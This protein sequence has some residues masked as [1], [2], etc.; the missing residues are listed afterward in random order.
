MLY[1][2]VRKHNDDTIIT[3]DT[4]LRKIYLSLYLCVRGSWRLNRTATY[5]PR[6]L[7][8][9]AFLSRSPELLN[10]GPGAQPLWVLVFSTASCL[11]LVWSPN[12][13]SGVWGLPLLGAGFLY[14]ILSPTGLVSKLTDFLSTLIYIIVQ[15]PPS[16]C[17][18]HKLHSFPH[19]QSAIPRPDAP[20]I[21]IGAFPILTA[22]PDRRSIYNKCSHSLMMD[23]DPSRTQN[24]RMGDKRRQ[25][26]RCNGGRC[27]IKGEMFNLGRYMRKTRRW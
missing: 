17:G 13:Q 21:Y 26:S 1:T 8:A 14:R 3:S 20:V 27:R 6:L 5:W 16:S 2:H 11:Q 23:S 9:S 22:R 10:R 18:R 24:H 12:S 4:V 19:P 15:R 25:K 7:W